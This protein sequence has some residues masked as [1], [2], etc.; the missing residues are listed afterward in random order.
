MRSKGNPGCWMDG[1]LSLGLT[2][3]TRMSISI[4]ISKH[5]VL[6]I[7][8]LVAVIMSSGDILA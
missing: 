6:L 3:D 5:R 2:S 7:L 4:K 1:L 8:T